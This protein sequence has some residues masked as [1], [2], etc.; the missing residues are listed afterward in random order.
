MKMCCRKTCSNPCLRKIQKRL[1]YLPRVSPVST[2]I[3]GTVFLISHF[4]TLRMK[5]ISERSE[6]KRDCFKCGANQT[7]VGCGSGHS[8]NGKMC[9]QC[10]GPRSTHAR[11]PMDEHRLE[12]P[13]CWQVSNHQSQITMTSFWTNHL[14][15]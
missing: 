13:C 1:R 5:E 8:D 4:N 6:M 2:R 14:L 11:I 7:S 3:S 15:L 9:G 10:V 12:I